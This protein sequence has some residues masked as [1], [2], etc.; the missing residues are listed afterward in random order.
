AATALAVVPVAVL[1]FVAPPTTAFMLRS[2]QADPATGAPCPD[3]AYTWVPREAIAPDLRLAVLVAEDQRF[4]QHR[5]FDFE[6]MR[7]AFR[8]R[9]RHGRRRGAS[10]LTQQLAKNLFLWPDATYTRK[11]VEAWF[12]FWLETLWPKERILEVY[13]NVAQFGACRFG[14]GSASRAFFGH[15]PDAVDAR[16]AAL[17]AAVLPSP[18]RMRA[19]DPGPYTRERTEAILALMAEHRGRLGRR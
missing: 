10:T 3:V 18:A 9:L 2:R 14:V 8:D 19:H 12:T 13:L 15:G 7:R 4:Y 5:G 1:R 17:L 6:S 16:E 11:L